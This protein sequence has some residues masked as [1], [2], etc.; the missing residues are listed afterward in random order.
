[1][2]QPASSS[3]PPGRPPR[4]APERPPAPARPALS[5][6]VPS[7]LEGL[8]GPAPRAVGRSL[9]LWVASFVVG[10]LVTGYVLTI[11]DELLLKIKLA[12]QTDDP[13]ITLDSLDRVATVSLYAALG[14]VLL[15]MVIEAILALIMRRRHNWA[16]VLLALVGVLSL[17]GFYVA[18]ELI[19]TGAPLRR[20]YV[21]L[22]LAA[23]GVLVL[24]AIL[25]MFAP[26]A[27]AWFRVH[28]RARR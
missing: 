8:V 21:Q 22:G 4:T 11:R 19:A 1:M 6:P 26:S 18:Q 12:V 5:V 24:A 3:G 9:T 10:A 15:V 2:S 13:T 16:R 28:H 17:P 20:N 25:M 27:N 7:P 14:G 23:Q